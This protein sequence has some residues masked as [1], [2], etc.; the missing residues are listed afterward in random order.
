MRGAAG[1]Y[2]RSA[3][4]PPAFHLARSSPLSASDATIVAPPPAAVKTTDLSCPSDDRCGATAIDG[5]GPSRSLLPTTLFGSASTM[6]PAIRYLASIG[7]VHSYTSRSQPFC[8]LLS[9]SV[10]DRA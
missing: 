8:Q 1:S 9:H 2:A 3:T 4:G 7:C 10:A 5:D 6:P